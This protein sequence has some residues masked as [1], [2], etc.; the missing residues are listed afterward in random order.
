VWIEVYIVGDRLGFGGQE[1]HRLHR[2]D[3]MLFFSS[4]SE[5]L[6]EESKGPVAEAEAGLMTCR[7]MVVCWGRAEYVAQ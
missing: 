4:V 7:G 2:L 5:G 3:E 1:T 6:S